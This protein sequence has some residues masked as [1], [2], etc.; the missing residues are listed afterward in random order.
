MQSPCAIR[1]IVKVVRSGATASSAV[2]TASTQRL[3]RMPSRGR[4]CRL[5]KRDREAR[6]RHAHGAGVDGEAHRCGRHFVGCGKRRQDRLRREQIDHGEKGGQADDDGP[7]Q[8]VERIA[9]RVHPRIGRI[10]SVIC[11]MADLRARYSAACIIRP[12]A[13]AGPRL[14]ADRPRPP[15]A[16][17]RARAWSW[18]S[19]PPSAGGCWSG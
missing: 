14:R 11:D 10:V 2:G 17:V 8:H 3:I 12:R 16:P 7:A 18:R 1:R 13:R 9:V 19:R 5:K 4:C 15:T 6:D